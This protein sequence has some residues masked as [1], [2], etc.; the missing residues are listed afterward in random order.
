MVAKKTT[1]RRISS[2]VRL[3][4]C[5]D[6]AEGATQTSLAEKYGLSQVRVSQILREDDV[7]T[8]TREEA[9]APTFDVD[10]AE[11]LY[12]DG[13][14]GAKVGAILGVSSGVVLSHMR[15]RGVTRS[16]GRRYINYDEAF[17]GTVD[18]LRSYWAGFIAADGCV[19]K[20]RVVIGLHPSDREL[21]DNLKKAALLPH[22]VIERAN[23]SGRKY[24]YLEVWCP[25]WVSDLWANFGVGPRKAKTL[26]PPSLPTEA[27]EWAFVRGYFDGD[28]H[29]A[30]GKS[31]F[32]ITSGSKPLLEWMIR[33]VMGSKHSI[34]A[35]GGSWGCYVCGPKFREI[36][37][38]LY[39]GSTVETRLARKYERLHG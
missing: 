12:R 27:D 3:S 8:R 5:R 23:G 4:I 36:V 15:R 24:A 39:E 33:E 17:F 29:A 7:P 35:S 14:S 37:P 19:Y 1:W 21:L 13:L 34:Y 9:N 25:Q 38:K 16:K 20:D 11:R 18:P 26:K 30:K 10:E 32:Q 6:Y 2:E 22:P 31:A 28:G